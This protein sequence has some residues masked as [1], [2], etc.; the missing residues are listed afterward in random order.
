MEAVRVATSVD[1]DGKAEANCCKQALDGMR[2][3]IP[4][5]GWR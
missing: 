2:R 4:D 5:H 1:A 3:S